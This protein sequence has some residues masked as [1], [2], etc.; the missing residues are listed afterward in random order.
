MK[1]IIIV[2]LGLACMLATGC[3]TNDDSSWNENANNHM[4]SS[5]IV[6][7]GSQS[8]AVIIVK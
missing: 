6:I 4:K 1:Q 7:D 8:N 3:W 2:V 5:T